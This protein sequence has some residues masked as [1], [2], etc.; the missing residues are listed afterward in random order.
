MHQLDIA[1]L[2]S[3]E[4][5]NKARRELQIAKGRYRTMTVLSFM[6]AVSTI[7]GCLSAALA[8]HPALALGWAPLIAAVTT[9]VLM[10]GIECE[11]RGLRAHW[12]LADVVALSTAAGKCKEA[13]VLCTRSSAAQAVREKALASGR[14][15]YVFDYNA[16]C[17]AVKQQEELATAS[18]HG[19]I[20]RELHGLAT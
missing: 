18:E 3:D 20:C 16:M 8:P 1:S 6:F 5:V 13:L 17:A 14:Q 2:T 19:A 11:Q 15:L 4:A 10:W 12:A 7:V 9:A